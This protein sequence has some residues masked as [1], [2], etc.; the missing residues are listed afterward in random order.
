[1]PGQHV[2]LLTF[3]GNEICGPVP[4]GLLYMPCFSL[5]HI[6]PPLLEMNTFGSGGV[7]LFDRKD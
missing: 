5:V 2:E 7:Q 6:Q 3:F 4:S 1:M